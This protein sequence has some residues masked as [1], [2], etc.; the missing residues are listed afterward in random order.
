MLVGH[1]RPEIE[2]LVKAHR[3]LL[4]HQSHAE[5]LL[6]KHEGHVGGH[7]EGL[8]RA[9]DADPLQ[10]RAAT[11]FQQVGGADRSGVVIVGKLEILGELR[12]RL[13]VGLQG[14]NQETTGHQEGNEYLF[15][16]EPSFHNRHSK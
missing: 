11:D 14:G 8:R 9:M 16:T 4:H 12:V 2:V 3:L 15:S 1:L 5:T 6:E 7:D 13:G 10:P